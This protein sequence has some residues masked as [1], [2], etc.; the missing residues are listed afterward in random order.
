ME[1]I[2]AGLWVLLGHELALFWPSTTSPRALRAWAG[3]DGE[4]T[5][6]RSRSSFSFYFPFASPASGPHCDCS[7]LSLQPSTRPQGWG[8]D[9]EGPSSHLPTPPPTQAGTSEMKVTINLS[10][11]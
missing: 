3:R 10:L 2:S 6:E 11:H 7:T 9:A 4:E 8:T 5:G 1:A